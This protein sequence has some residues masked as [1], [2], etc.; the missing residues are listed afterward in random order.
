MR[1][2]T[3]DTPIGPLLATADEDDGLTG[4]WFDRE[5][6]PGAEPAPLTAVREQLAAYFA[7]G[8][9]DGFDLPLA[10]AGTAWQRAVWDA[11]V[12]IPYGQTVSYGQ[13]AARLGRPHAAR[14]VG[15]A[16]G[17]NPLSVV[18]P[19]HRLVGATGALTGYGGGISR[20][21]WLL[22][23]EAAA[24]APGPSVRRSSVRARSTPAG[25]AGRSSAAF[26][27]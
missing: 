14:A 21:E 20:K 10:A 5:P 22:R 12:Q 2:A 18:V 15:A 19:C 4:L 3:I 16:N 26:R 7:G 24:T 11:L 17:R 9:R 25:R 27:S 6:P 13:L 1:A 8:L 23:H